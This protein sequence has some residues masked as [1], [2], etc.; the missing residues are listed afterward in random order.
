MHFCE[1]DILDALL[2]VKSFLIRIVILIHA[3]MQNIF[4]SNV[5]INMFHPFTFAQQPINQVEMYPAIST[6]RIMKKQQ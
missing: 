5:I 4:T 6:E 3:N 2:L 1:N